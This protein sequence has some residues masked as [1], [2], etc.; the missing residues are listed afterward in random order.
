MKTC[1]LLT[2]FALSSYAGFIDP[3]T[4]PSL[5][6]SWSVV[7]YT[8]PFPRAHGE[9]SP[10][11]EFSLS[12]NPGNLRYTLNPMTHSD[13][14][15]NGYATTSGVH[16]CCTHDAGLEISRPL[17]GDNWVLETRASYFLPFS[18]GRTFNF[19]VYFGD[20][21]PD[22]FQARF[23]RG[24]DTGYNNVQFILA[25][26]PGA[27]PSQ[28][29]ISYLSAPDYPFSTSANTVVYRLV[30][31]GGVLTAQWSDDDGTSFQT[32]Y[33]TDL[34]NA[35]D[36]LD[37]RVSIAGLSWFNPAGSYADYDY[38][39]FSD[40]PE[41]S[42]LLLSALALGLLEIKRRRPTSIT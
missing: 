33:S 37:Q 3:F 28:T 15:L 24:R 12:A 2:A 30:R 40:V 27:F 39:S 42:S 26:F 22:T 13:G 19:D 9:T 32:A 8:G 1:I 18:N 25:E 21:G 29:G 16:S 7:T 36:G 23:L 10:A 31:S 11:N 14:F 34:G 20:G 4:S 6:P 5:D 35:L 17:T 38:V 41:P